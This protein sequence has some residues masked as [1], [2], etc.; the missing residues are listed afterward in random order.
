MSHSTAQT[1]KEGF[2]K[3][4]IRNKVGCWGWSGCCPK[5]PG[6]GQFRSNMKIIRAHRASWIIHYGEIPK[7]KFVCH[8]CDNP[9]CSNPDHLFL[10]TCKDNNYDCIKKG[11]HPTL[12]KKGEDNHCAVITAKIA[13]KIKQLLKETNDQKKIAKIFNIS[14]YIVSQIKCNKTWRGI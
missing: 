2:E 10:G 4:V 6:Y 7:G 8:K 3:F 12:G 14:S 1:I 13:K 5:N 11:R 9:I